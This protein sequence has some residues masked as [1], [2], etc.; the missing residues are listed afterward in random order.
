MYH[1]WEGSEMHAK[2]WCEN[3]KYEYR[4]ELTDVDEF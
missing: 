1:A 4:Q 3:E 2:F